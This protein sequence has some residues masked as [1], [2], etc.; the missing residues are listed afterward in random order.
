MHDVRIGKH[1][2]PTKYICENTSYNDIILN[3]PHQPYRTV[4][5]RSSSFIQAFDR[6]FS[7]DNLLINYKNLRIRSNITII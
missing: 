4:F 7:I 1:S 6:L 2:T 3:Y 5:D